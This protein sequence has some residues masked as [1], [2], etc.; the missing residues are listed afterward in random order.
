[1]SCPETHTFGKSERIVSRKLIDTLF[2]GGK[3]RSLAAFP[4][5][6]VYMLTERQHGMAPVQVM[7]SVPKRHFK[8]AVKRNRVKRQVRESYRLNKQPLIDAMSAHEGAT[9]AVTF[10]W[11]A[12]HLYETHE[13]TAAVNNILGRLADRL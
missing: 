10:I 11:Q 3:S 9:L 13:V 2:G 4:L 6:A 1:M 12:D 8:R 7:V 5:R